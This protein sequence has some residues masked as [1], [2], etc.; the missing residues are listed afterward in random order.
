MLDDPYD[1]GIVTVPS[2]LLVLGTAAWAD[3]WPE[4]SESMSART[5]AVADR[6]GIHLQSGD[7]EA[8]VVQA[9]PGPLPVRAE[10][11]LSPFSYE[12]VITVLEVSLGRPWSADTARDPVV[13]GDLPVSR[14]GMILGDATALD[15]YVG[16]GD[17]STDGLA[18]VAYWGRHA[19][20]AR[21][22]FGGDV[23][24]R[25]GNA[26]GWLDVPVEE[27][28]A[29]E[30]SLGAWVVEHH[31]GIG[32]MTSVDEHTDYTRLD[33]ATWNQPLGAATSSLA[34]C[35]VLGI[36]W[37]GLDHAHRHRP[38]RRGGCVYPVTLEPDGAGGTLLRWTI[39]PGQAE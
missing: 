2:G 27:A 25:P 8:V 28:E 22:V 9:A 17:D 21:A 35:Q 10:T 34:G 4:A 13:I 33:R 5:A 38:E 19:D 14:T 30:D 20:E 39:P 37:D 24:P 15:T 23:L 1:L 6:G 7:V 3:Y 31:Q 29:L 18:D 36:M 32:L 26:Y 11:W 16:L 12:L